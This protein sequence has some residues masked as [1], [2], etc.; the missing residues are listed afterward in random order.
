MPDKYEIRKY[1]LEGNLLTKIKRNVR[2]KPPNIKI[3]NIR[4]HAGVSVGPSDCSGPCYMVNGKYLINYLQLVDKKDEKK[5]EIN[6]L[7]FPLHILNF[8]SSYISPLLIFI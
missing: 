3:V 5:Y 6:R 4:G 8:K 1:N 7:K 2:L